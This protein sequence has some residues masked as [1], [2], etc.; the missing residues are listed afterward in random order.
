MN[1]TASPSSPHPLDPLSADE[2]SAWAAILARAS[3]Y[4]QDGWRIAAI[5][6]AEPGKAELAAYASG[7]ER[8]PRRALVLCFDR[9][10]NATYRAFVSL[11]A[12]SVE[13][14]EHVPGVQANF[15]V[16]EYLEC[17][18]MLRTHPDVLAALAKRGITDMDLVF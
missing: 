3:A 14:F 10:A 18:E 6:L 7:G 9:S 16:D 12:D 15:T 11:S 1:Q 5:E 2:F 8:P 17:D 13:S 4:Q